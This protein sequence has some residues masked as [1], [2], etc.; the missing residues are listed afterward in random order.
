M[1]FSVVA[2]LPLLCGCALVFSGQHDTVVVNVSYEIPQELQPS[3][4]RITVGNQV[5][6]LKGGRILIKRAGA[7]LPVRV[8]C[9]RPG[10]TATVTPAVVTPTFSVGYLIVDI[11]PGMFL[12]VI[13]LVV[14]LATGALYDYPD[15]ISLRVDVRWA[16]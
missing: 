16:R 4:L 6:P 1:R 3:D 13:P 10:Y 8:E 15:F 7:S 12:G 9:L 14:D 2:L 11:F 5:V